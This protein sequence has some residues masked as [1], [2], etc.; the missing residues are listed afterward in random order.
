MS[1]GASSRLVAV[2]SPPIKL[3]LEQLHLFRYLVDQHDQALFFANIQIWAW[4]CSSV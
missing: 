4:I 1:G 3:T 2:V